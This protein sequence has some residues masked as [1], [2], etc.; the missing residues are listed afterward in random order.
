MPPADPQTQRASD[1][2]RGAHIE[3]L[4]DAMTLRSAPSPRAPRPREVHRILACVTTGHSS[5]AV[6]AWARELSRLFGAD[7]TLLHVMTPVPAVSGYP[8]LGWGV[9]AP[10]TLPPDRLQEDVAIAE[11]VL[12]EARATLEA[13]IPEVHV[14]RREGHA[15]A[16]IV[17][18]A[19]E[20]ASDL[21]I[22]GPFEGGRID[23]LVLG[24]T[25]AHV[26]DHAE[27]NV[28]IA[29]APPAH[30]P[31]LA[32]VDG[33]APSRAAAALS[34][35]IARRWG[36]PL[37][38]LHVLPR[39]WQR[40]QDPAMLEAL[41]TQ[42]LPEGVSPIP[43]VS[44]D[45]R[46]GDPREEVPEAATRLGACLVVAGARGESALRSLVLGSTSRAVARTCPT[47][48]LLVRG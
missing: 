43:G 20:L 18:A 39:R 47:S 8:A 4:I 26:R 19:R 35:A 3:S 48:V 7:V 6:L 5:E 32:A 45:V 37:Q 14:L 29:R 34:D 36:E 28:L 1:A 23:R 17:R 31:V 40:A 44:L 25:T 9:A 38:L 12:G 24:S 46:A 33:S 15:G 10:V 11:R 42:A 16:E 27:T 22:L 2:E 41:R 13:D 30:G 21:V